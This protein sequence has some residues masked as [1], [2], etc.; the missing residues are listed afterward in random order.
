MDDKLRGDA[1]TPP[2]LP[3]RHGAEPVPALLASNGHG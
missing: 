2:V 3:D 1:L